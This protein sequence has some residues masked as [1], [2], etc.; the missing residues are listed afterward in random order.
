MKQFYTFVGAIMNRDNMPCFATPVYVN[1]G[2]FFIQEVDNKK[3]TLKEVNSNFF[4]SDKFVRPVRYHFSEDYISNNA[5]YCYAFD[6]N[7]RWIGNHKEISDFIEE[8]Y[9]KYKGKFKNPFV[10]AE[11]VEFVGIEKKGL[12]DVFEL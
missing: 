5:L 9:K 7:K 6:E 12:S 1:N 4:V 2:K 10:L 11:V 3:I 8:N